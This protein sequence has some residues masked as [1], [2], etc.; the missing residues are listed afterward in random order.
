ML[1]APRASSMGKAAGFS[2]PWRIAPVL[3]LLLSF[4]EDA[5]SRTLVNNGNPPLR[6]LSLFWPLPRENIR[7]NKVLKGTK[8]AR[9]VAQTPEDEHLEHLDPFPIG[10]R[11]SERQEEQGAQDAQA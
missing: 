10:K 9:Q 2:K 7:N 4:R 5:P 8:D 11:F 3:F 6:Q 1:R